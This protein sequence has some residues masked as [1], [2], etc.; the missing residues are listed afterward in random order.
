[1]SV[2]AP[3]QGEHG[4]LIFDLLKRQFVEAKLL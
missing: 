2:F 1:M 4:T 3:Y